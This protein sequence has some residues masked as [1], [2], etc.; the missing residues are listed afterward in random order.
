MLTQSLN[1]TERAEQPPNTTKLLPLRTRLQRQKSKLSI[2]KRHVLSSAEQACRDVQM[3]RHVQTHMKKHSWLLRLKIM[4]LMRSLKNSCPFEQR[5]EG[6]ETISCRTASHSWLTS[7]RMTVLVGR[8]PPALHDM[9]Q[10]DT[11]TQEHLRGFGDRGRNS[12]LRAYVLCRQH[13]TQK[14]ANVSIDALKFHSLKV[15]AQRTFQEKNGDMPN[16]N[17]FNVVLEDLCLGFL[18]VLF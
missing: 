4:E 8:I 16:S 18:F 2:K 11:T 14:L 3:H 17:G 13:T 9:T 12:W 7:K 15:W 5:E 1:H 10:K 6:T